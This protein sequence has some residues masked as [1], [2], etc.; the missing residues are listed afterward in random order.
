MTKT[1]YVGMSAD[2]LH[3]GHINIITEAAKLGNVTVGVLSDEAISTY[4]R[5]PMMALQD[6]LAIVSELRG[7]ERVVV[8]STLS[9]RTN[10]ENL[11]P[12][13]VVHG[14]DWKTGTQEETRKE[15]LEVLASYGGSLVEVPYTKNVSSTKFI[16]M[17]EEEHFLPSVRLSRLKRSLQ[18]KGAIRVI[19]SHSGLTAAIAEHAGNRENHFDALWLSSLTDSTLRGKPDIEVVGLSPR[20]Q[21]LRD[22]AEITRKPFIFDGDTGGLPEHFHY[23]VQSLEIAGVS[24][25]IIEDKVGLKR[26]SLYGTEVP[27]AQS[28][29]KEFSEKLRIG[30]M[31]KRSEDFYIIARIESLIFDKGIEDA[32]DRAETYMANGANGIM[33]HSRKKGGAE[34]LDF[35]AKFRANDPHTP[36]VVV[37]SSFPELSFEQLKNAGANIVIYANQLLRASYPAMLNAANKI[38]EDGSSLSV[39]NEIMKISEILSLIPGAN[40]AN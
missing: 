33:I 8:Q 18:V 38:L 10:L 36:L 34:I 26:N 9:Y 17:L 11:K 28:N 22:M 3:R 12:D 15:V 27:Q 40:L 32:L 37:P 30:Q 13:Y 2:I 23:M 35:I 16:E 31:A 24:A 29:K 7:V 4:K 39:E 14:D 6:R 25:V 1:V 19:E 5:I 21:S 20:L